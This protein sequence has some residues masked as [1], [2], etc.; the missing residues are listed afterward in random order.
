MYL[1]VVWHSRIALRRNSRLE[2]T[3]AQLYRSS[4]AQTTYSTTTHP[5]VYATSERSGRQS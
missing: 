3:H 2:G 5:L 4:K 1:V